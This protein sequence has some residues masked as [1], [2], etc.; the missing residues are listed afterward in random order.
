MC[1]MRQGFDQGEE[2]CADDEEM[3]CMDC[4]E[5]KIWMRHGTGEIAESLG[6]EI[7]RYKRI[8]KPVQPIPIPVIHGQVCMF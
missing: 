2:V 7:T 4:L 1:R 6:Y 5:D 8:E 3:I